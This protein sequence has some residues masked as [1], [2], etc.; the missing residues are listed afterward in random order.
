MHKCLPI[1]LPGIVLGLVASGA[2]GATVIPVRIEW[3]NPIAAATIGDAELRVIVDSG[4]RSL[5][6]RPETLEK[7]A[8]FPAAGSDVGVDVG[9]DVYGN[10][11]ETGSFVV[12][13]VILGGSEF[14]NIRGYE[15]AIPPGV[16]KREPAVDG[17]VGR[18][19]L[20]D[21]KVVYDYGNSTISLHESGEPDVVGCGGP[22]IPLAAHPEDVIVTEVLLDHGT[23]LGL[24]DSGATHSFIK[25]DA[26]KAAG[27]PL[28]SVDDQ[29]EAYNSERFRLGSIDFGPLDFVSLPLVQPEGVDLFVGYNFFSRHVVCIDY[30][31]SSI[32]VQPY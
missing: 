30:K 18:A 31:Q 4:G 32:Q 9:V 1:I 17:I 3:G 25:A 6:I 21:F 13:S 26:A 23:F 8:E 11:T 19:F 29:V 16:A 15:W 22:E 2:D 14:S 10:K 5:G 24:W 12:P 27:V 20:N 7:L 28:E